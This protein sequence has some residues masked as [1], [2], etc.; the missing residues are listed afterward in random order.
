MHAP[1]SL[2]IQCCNARKHKPT[3]LSACGQ[4][5]RETNLLEN[6]DR[7]T[8][9]RLVP[10]TVF[11]DPELGR[12]GLTE[13]QA[14]AK[15]L[16]IKVAQMPMAHAARAVT[17]LGSFRDRAQPMSEPIVEPVNARLAL[18]SNKGAKRTSRIQNLYS[19]RRARMSTLTI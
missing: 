14:R 4:I 15:G 5:D 1:K 12:V 19:T 18:P 16:T 11:I 8:R 13:H 7:T 9:D 17:D 6:G 3:Q 2:P 10:Y